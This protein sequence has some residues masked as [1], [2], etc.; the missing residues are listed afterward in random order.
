MQIDAFA[1]S[2]HVFGF[3]NEKT[4]WVVQLEEEIINI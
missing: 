1:Y 3:A 4:L 2:S